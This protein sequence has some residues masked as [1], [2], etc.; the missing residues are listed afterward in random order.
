MPS[1]PRHTIVQA[2]QVGI[3][4]CYNR[5][6]RRAFLCG[7]DPLTGR[8][9][10]HRKQ[11]CLQRL[12]ELAASFAIDA[13]SYA[14]LDNHLHVVL[15]IR[16]D[17]ARSWSNE[18]VARRWWQLCPMRRDDQG[19]PADPYPFELTIWLCDP[20]KIE[21]LRARLAN[22]SWFMKFLSEAIARRANREDEVT[23]RFWEGRFKSQALLDEAAVLACSMYVDLNPIRAGKAHAPEE[24]R[25]TSAYDRIGALLQANTASEPQLPGSDGAAEPTCSGPC[26][27]PD[28]WLCP[29]PLGNDLCDSESSNSFPASRA[30]EKGF[31]P[32]E[33]AEYLE[34]LDWT[35][36]QLR[37]GKRGAIPEALAPIGVRLRIDL[38]RWPETVRNFPRCYRTAAGR[39]E[40]LERAAG[41]AGRRWLVGVRHARQAFG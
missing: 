16:P 4:H 1:R 40:N 38:E 18:E 15:R 17:I 11:W 27:S 26:R 19:L 22:L 23:G 39:A 12:Q 3:Y 28:A 24:A 31:L 13:C 36:R 9:F 37:V 32:M 41:R 35:G 8:N 29:L 10:D 2:D 21:Q 25:F 6:V 5:C 30:S 7:H 14:L 34:L 33:L 20:A